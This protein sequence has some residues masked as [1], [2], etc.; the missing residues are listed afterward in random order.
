MSPPTTSPAA[1]APQSSAASFAKGLEGIVAG[2]SA[3]CSV[4]QGNLIYRGYEIHDLAEN[5]T[6]EEVA[7]LLLEGHKPS[8]DELARFNQEIVSERALPEAVVQYLV[9]AG[10]MLATRIDVS[11][12]E[13]VERD[14]FM[15]AD[16]VPTSA[17]R[18]AEAE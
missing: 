2:E 18:L 1:A 3:I 7:F 13:I 10:P 16:L 14:G 15:F 8:K 5:A 4:E 11:L 12:G 9:A 17:T 6:F